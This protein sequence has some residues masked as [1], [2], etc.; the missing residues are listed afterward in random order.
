MAATL[1][2]GLTTTLTPSAISSSHVHFLTL[3]LALTLSVSHKHTHKPTHS[4]KT[5][6]Y[7]ILTLNH[8]YPDYDFSQLR[9]D[10]FK[11]E[12]GYGRVEELVDTHMLEVSRVRRGS[13]GGQGR[14][15]EQIREC[16][17]VPRRGWYGC[18]H[19]RSC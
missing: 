6:I 19:R 2:G 15:G 7:L 9:A 5:L 11:K 1:L 3:S 16:V 17:A 8:I 10:D 18:V 4:R 13:R 14:G 12:Q